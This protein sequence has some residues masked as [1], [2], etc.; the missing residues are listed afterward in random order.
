MTW[1]SP[2]LLHAELNNEYQ[3]TMKKER[4]H[5]TTETKESII[6]NIVF[7]LFEPAVPAIGLRLSKNN[8]INNFLINKRLFE[9]LE[10]WK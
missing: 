10:L 8:N 6:V 4:N 3:N 2:R 9:K 1:P 5:P 7:N